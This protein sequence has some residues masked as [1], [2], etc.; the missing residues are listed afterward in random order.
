MRARDLVDQILTFSRQAGSEMV[1]VNLGQVIKD[2]RRFLRATIPATVHLEVVIAPDCESAMADATQIY[3]VLLNLS[4]NAVHAM[5]PAGGAIK[6]ELDQVTQACDANNPLDQLP[7]GR[8]LRLVF[9]D[10]GQGMDEE[11]CKRIFDPFFTTKAVGKGTGLGL[12][13][14]HGIVQAHRGT[15]AVSSQPGVGTTFTILI[16]AADG[17]CSDPA[18]VESNVPRGNGELIA[19]VDDEE[20]IRSFAQMALERFGYRVKV[21][22]NP[23]ACLEE[24]RQNSQD[25]DALLTDQTMPG[26]PGIELAAAVRKL[27]PGL[28]IIIMSGYFSRIS[29][30]NLAKLGRV[31]LLSKPFTK[32]ELAQA[33][34]RA[35]QTELGALPGPAPA[36]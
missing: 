2:A 24:L 27:A 18:L 25:Y 8:Y 29:A 31:E 1:P 16:P 22:D 5:P 34:H 3:Q 28:L 30:D 32:E 17:L 15:I 6:L 19:L 33:V 14:V 10:N 35:F 13:V 11:T 20:I 9:S 12:S 4:S 7:P 26:M 23:A 36:G 21:F